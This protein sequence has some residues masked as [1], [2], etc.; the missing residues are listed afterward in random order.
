MRKVVWV[1]VAVMGATGFIAS[2]I[3]NDGVYLRRAL[4]ATAIGFVFG[5]IYFIPAFVATARR[6]PN[7]LGIVVLNAL[8][9]WTI[10]GWVGSMVWSVLKI[11]RPKENQ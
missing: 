5:A 11:E 1:L 2:V 7:M 10:L 4:P 3:G 8:G 6:H 9:G